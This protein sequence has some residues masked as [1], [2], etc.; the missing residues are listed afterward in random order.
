M[1][2]DVVW[3]TVFLQEAFG[4]LVREESFTVR[5]LELSLRLVASDSSLVTEAWLYI[6]P[7]GPRR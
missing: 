6:R 7:E 1:K 4:G 3:I 2:K 5:E